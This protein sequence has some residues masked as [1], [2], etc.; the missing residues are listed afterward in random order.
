[1]RDPK[2]VAPAVVLGLVLVLALA[3]SLVTLDTTDCD[4]ARSLDGPSLGHPLGVDLLGCDLLAEVAHG[5]RAS[6][7]IAAIVVLISVGIAIVLGGLSGWFGGIVDVLISRATEVWFSVP[8]ILGGLLILSF[9]ERPGVVSVALVLSLFGWPPMTRV[10][11]SSVIQV[12]EREFV[13]ASLALGAGDLRLLVHHVLPNALQPVL[14]FAT[15]Y[16]GVVI[17]V[18]ATLTFLGVG[19]SLPE[20]SWGILLSEAQGR[21]RQ[22]PHL[23]WVP[24]A[25]LAATVC[26]FVVLGEVLRDVVDPHRRSN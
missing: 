16:A 10:M 25:A 26:S 19:L 23:L 15:L 22:A 21:F 18:E 24:S 1:M 6:L 17:P 7:A 11:R 14:V 2:F 3:P 20:Q 12:R 8:L 5:A 4:L 9:I 13:Q